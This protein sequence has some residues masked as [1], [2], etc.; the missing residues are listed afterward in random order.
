MKKNTSAI[1]D[2]VSHDIAFN[3]TNINKCMLKDEVVTC[4]A[5]IMYG[6]LKLYKC[7]FSH[8][9]PF[10]NSKS[11]VKIFDEIFSWYLKAIESDDYSIQNDNIDKT[12]SILVDECK[13][14]CNASEFPC[15]ASLMD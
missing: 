1:C 6:I 9:I 8:I 5:M 2:D 7:D 10:I 15:V 3:D 11:D 13:R 14:Y 12:Y 4:K